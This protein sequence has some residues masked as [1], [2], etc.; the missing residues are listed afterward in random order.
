MSEAPAHQVWAVIP[1]LNEQATLGCVLEAARAEGLRTLVVDD[2]STDETSGIAGRLAD[3][4]I[5]H[6][7]PHGYAGALASGMVTLAKRSDV[8]WAVTLDADGQL[9]PR[10]AV[11]LV[12]GA[13][14][15]GAAVAVGIRERPPRVLERVAAALCRAVFGIADPFCG[16]KAVRI[17]TLRRYKGYAGRNVNLALVVKALLGGDRLHQAPVRSAPRVAGASRFGSVGVN[18]RMIKAILIVLAMRL[19]PGSRP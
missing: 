6:A 4:C 8:S 18:L 17:D 7:H 15:A 13:E 19:R 16:V 14:Q 2:G 9:E 5:R 12:R 1:A 11:A 10:D 3:E